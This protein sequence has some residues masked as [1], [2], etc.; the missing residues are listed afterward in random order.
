M[1]GWMTI[2]VERTTLMRLAFPA[3]RAP[4]QC[5]PD[6]GTVLDRDHA[7]LLSTVA[8]RRAAPTITRERSPACRSCP[9]GL[10]S[11]HYD[12]SACVC[13]LSA[14]ASIMLLDVRARHPCCNIVRFLASCCCIVCVIFVS[15]S[16]A[17]GAQERFV[18]ESFRRVDACNRAHFYLWVS[19]RCG[20]AIAAC[21]RQCRH[22]RHYTALQ[23][24][25]LSVWMPPSPPPVVTLHFRASY[26][27][28]PGTR[29]LV[30]VLGP[31]HSIHA[32]SSVLFLL[33]RPKLLCNA[34]RF[35]SGYTVLNHDCE[36]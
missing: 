13:T 10:S 31:R 30:V 22:M 3:G 26:R 15:S 14:S 12:S 16:R 1:A 11:S 36:L 17:F 7:R 18:T 21:D 25:R 5:N 23:S 35:G 2:I 28:P 33:S 20:H 6:W 27:Y 9:P 19:N 32:C 24:S 29:S 34:C 4:K 8:D